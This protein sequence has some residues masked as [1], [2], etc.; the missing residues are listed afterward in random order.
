METIY[1]PLRRKEVART[2]EEEVRQGVIAWLHSSMGVPLVRMA[3][4]WGFTYNRRR[5]RAD[6]VVFDRS[7]Q[8]RLL[9]ECKA[10]GVPLDGAVVEQVVRYT[11]VLK[12]EY[13]MVTDG[14][15][16]HLLSRRDDGGYSPAASLP[17]SF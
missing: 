1:D 3:S 4:E 8:P 14:T 6:V 17:E 9:V 11:R 10:P 5:Y 7:L 16:T 15:V 2:P 12:V 13:I